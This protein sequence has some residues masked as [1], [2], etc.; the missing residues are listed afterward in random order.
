MND[1]RHP[2]ARRL[3]SLHLPPE[4][5][6]E[7]VEELSQHLDDRYRE[8]RASGSSES[9]ARREALAELDDADLVSE[10]T[11]VEPR[12]IEPH[13]LGSPSAAGPLSGLWQDVRFG[14]RLLVKERG[15]SFVIVTTLSLAIAANALVF[16]F[17]DLVLFRPL[18]LGNEKRLATIFAADPQVSRDRQRVSLVDYL[19]IK[20][21][22]TAFEDV[23][24][25]RR[26]Q[27]SLTGAGEPRAVSAAFGTANIFDVWNVKAVVG[28]LLRPEDGEI[29]RS[30]V[31][32]LA[33]HFWKGHFDADPTVVGR[34]VTLNGRGY[35]VVGVVTPDLEIGN[36]GEIDLW[37]PLDTA[38]A[39]ERESRVLTVQGLL[40]PGATLEAANVE[41][42]TIADRLA[43]AYPAASKGWRL[44][45]L[46]LRASTVGTNASVIL[47]L[48]GVVVALVLIVACANVATV[49]LARSSA[50]R[51]E[52]AVRLAL[53]AT[54]ARLVRQLV[55]EN[56]MIG[57][58]SGAFGLLLAREGFVG[59]K[60]FSPETFWQR[61]EMNGNLL[62][63][64]FALSVITPLLFGVLP[65]LQSARPDLNEDLKEGGRDASSSV[66]GNRSRS[67]LVV[68]QIAFALAVLIVSG[69]VVRT[70]VGLEHVPLGMNPDGMLTTRV[71]FDPPKYDTDAVRLRA[72]ESIL[73]R[74]SALPG[75]T[76]AA[77]MR[78]FPIVDGEGRRQFAIAGRPAVPAG[79]APWAAEAATYGEYGRTIA[80]PL[81]EGRTWNAG[82]R[83]SGWAVAVVNREAVRRYW[84]AQSPVGDRITMLD[85]A[86][87]PTGHPIDII[88]VVDNV[89]GGDISEPPPPRIYRPLPGAGSLESVGFAV[90]ASGD[91][92]A[93]APSIRAVLR[94]EDRDLA[95]SEIQ[96]ARHDLDMEMR[97]N[98]LLVALFTS[99]A[100]IGLVVAITG[101]YG[102]TAFSVGQRRHEIGVRMALGATGAD[103]MRL[104]AAR[105]FRLIAIGAALG[106]LSGWSIGL[107]MRNALFGVGVADPLTYAAVLGIIG[108]C[109][110]VATYL[111]AHR[112]IA[113]DP[114]AVL[115][116]E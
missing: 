78:S 102:V 104:V 64:G 51:R 98:A 58:A 65:A 4:R 74:L 11:G 37:I 89:L 113:I 96:S 53:G 6:A 18:P 73:D 79:S 33:H 31:V 101:V 44:F 116:R 61:L 112:A 97:T 50:R 82:D 36:L 94:A 27:L 92:A 3:D 32:A 45:A 107:A 41:L 95:A 35:T 16:G 56:L 20:S 114:M 10:L 40:K 29:G 25:M 52:I 15:V 38:A 72:V 7:V 49:M 54:Q 23:A 8:L 2:I 69:L 57:L 67:V 81:L 91:T 28:R 100:A 21:Q 1:W 47:M 62:A 42:A 108:V 99:F 77:A 93:L 88:G 90:R 14:A 83:A 110:A 71:R 24:G 76:A 60:T 19:E 105:S 12:A 85:S 59:F 46:T 66:R 63:F 106:A 87:L 43:R 80:L 103:V 68:A 17:A 9:I 84:P 39:A 22:S 70:V 30:Q 86:G 109:G 115:K 5:E 26:G 75:V 34:S 48:L 111:P 13:P 55:S